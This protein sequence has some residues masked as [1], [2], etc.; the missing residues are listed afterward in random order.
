MNV[1]GYAA[2]LSAPFDAGLVAAG[3]DVLVLTATYTISS[4]LSIVTGTIND[5]V[6]IIGVNSSGVNDGSMATITTAST[7]AN[8]L[9]DYTTTSIDYT[10]L[11]NL[12]L[13]GG[14]AGK[15]EHCIYN[16]N[17]T[18]N[19][20][21]LVNCQLTNADNHGAV[22]GSSVHS[23]GWKFIGCEVD[24][25]G[26]GVA[27]GGGLIGRA[28]GIRF[29]GNILDCNIHDNEGDGILAGQDEVLISR[30]RVYSNT[31]IGINLEAG[32][33]RA[34]V[35]YNMCYGNGGAG[36]RCD[37]DATDLTMY[38]NTSSGNT[39][40]GYDIDGRSNPMEYFGNNHSHN[41]TGTPATG[42][43]SET[44]SDAEWLAFGNN[45]NI[46]GDPLFV[47]AGSD[48]FRLTSA[49]PLYDSTTGELI[50]VLGPEAA[51]GGG[52]LINGGLLI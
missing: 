44:A 50:G 42:H 25:N 2:S 38:N 17:D 41:N 49:S 11:E 47:N 30:N 18:S 16:N 45:D 4:S 6:S 33:I 26:V 36:I 22:L 40:V 34:V 52:M 3:D 5:L 27:G 1:G 21:V 35:T 8:G 48:D 37:A 19:N 7:L 31:G 13:D 9:L 32:A 39:G 23:T 51:G 28:S 29:T 43:C 12:I 10:Y 14:G 20:N 15:A 24:N 46:I